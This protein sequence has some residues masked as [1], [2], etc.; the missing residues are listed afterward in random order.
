MSWGDFYRLLT[1]SDAIPN[2]KVGIVSESGLGSR[3]IV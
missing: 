3:T 2:L 1:G